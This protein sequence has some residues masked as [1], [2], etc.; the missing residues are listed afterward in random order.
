MPDELLTISQAASYL[1]LSDKT[2]RRLIKNS[3]MTASKVGD[4]AWR[5]RVADIED[6]L[7]AHTNGRKGVKSK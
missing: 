2:I 7:R 6:Y 5:I 4:R 3:Q 1:Q